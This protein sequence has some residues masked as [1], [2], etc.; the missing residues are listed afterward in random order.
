M[1]RADESLEVVQEV[2][3]ALTALGIPYA[4]GGSMASSLLGR[5]RF[6]QDADIT[7]EPF[8]GRE[9]ALVAR[10]DRDYYV[11]LPAVLDAVRRQSSFNIIHTPSGFKVDVFIRKDRLFEQSVMARRRA[12]SVPG[13]TGQELFVVGPEDIILLKLEWYRLGGETSERQW[14]DVLNVLQVQ[15]G[16]LDEAYLDHWAADL[17]V[18]DLLARARQESLQ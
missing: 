16:H 17:K 15:A 11:T 9:A 8:A 12:L 2:A 3:A 10:F 5:P 1:E 4:L 13:Q 14:K 7:V 6:T 18:D